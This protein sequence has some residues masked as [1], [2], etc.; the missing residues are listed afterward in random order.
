MLSPELIAEI[1]SIELKAQHLATDIL[2]GE[3]A[4]AFHGRGMEFQE[5]REYVPGDDVRAIDWNVTARMNVPFVKIFREERELTIML[6]VDVSPSQRFGSVRSRRDVTAELAAVVAWLAIRNN[7]R[8]G[9]LLFSD[10]VEHYVP[11]RKGRG[12]VWRVIKDVLSHQG[13]GGKTDLAS[14]FDYVRRIQP[15]R[16][17]C[18][19]ISD[20]WCQGFESS[21][22]LLAKQHDVACVTVTDP[23]EDQLPNA[24]VVEWVDSESGELL[25]IDTSDPVVRREFDAAAAAR[26]SGRDRVFAGAGVQQFSV[27]TAS[28]VVPPLIRYLRDRERGGRKA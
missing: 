9:L 14:A 28:S 25:L 23:S 27:S 21:L 6:V 13:R 15:R 22:K 1:K 10:H 20:F 3:Y 5:V 11:P 12:H 2:S 4:S 19:V 7:D 8:V 18:F 26:R 17:T 24:G 16:A